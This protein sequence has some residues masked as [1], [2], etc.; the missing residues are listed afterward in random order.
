MVRLTVRKILIGVRSAFMGLSKKI[1][2]INQRYATPK[3]RMSRSVKIILFLLRIYLLFLVL[4][5]GY[6]FWTLVR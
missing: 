2:A 4:L 6:K 1:S 3:I 5:L